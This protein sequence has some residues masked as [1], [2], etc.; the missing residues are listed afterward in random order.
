M[1]RNKYHIYVDGSCD[2][3]PG[4]GGW[5]FIIIGNKYIK[6]ATG[7]IDFCTNNKMELIA[8]IQGLKAVEP[9]SNIFLHT[10]SQYV[11]DTINTGR[12]LVWKTNGWKRMNNGADVAYKELWI[13]LINITKHKDLCVTYVKSKAHAND[14]KNNRVDYLAKKTSK[15][16]IKP[17]CKIY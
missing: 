9:H 4:K 1:K 7:F 6:E 16:E 5:A 8:T 14:R 12:I 3:N 11:F 15:Q 10:D 2:G 13:E 17:Y